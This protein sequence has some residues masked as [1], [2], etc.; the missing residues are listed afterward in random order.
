MSFHSTVVAGVD[1]LFEAV[2]GSSDDILRKQLEVSTAHVV[3]FQ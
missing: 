2:A 1:R 3:G